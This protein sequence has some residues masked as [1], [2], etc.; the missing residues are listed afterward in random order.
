MKIL[1]MEFLEKNNTTGSDSSV[2]HFDR[3]FRRNF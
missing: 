3:N 1:E 2:L